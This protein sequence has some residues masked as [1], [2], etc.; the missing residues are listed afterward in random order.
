MKEQSRKAARQCLLDLL[1]CTELEKDINH[2]ILDRW[3]RLS[4]AQ[5]KPRHVGSLRHHYFATSLLGA[6]SES[7][8]HR[9][10]D[11]KD[12]VMLLARTSLLG[13]KDVSNL[14]PL[15]ESAIVYDVFPAGARFV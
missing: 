11:D 2:A 15:N 9:G 14:R 7:Q 1:D 10:D 3:F 13:S 5:T 6:Y 8:Y 12:K 4:A